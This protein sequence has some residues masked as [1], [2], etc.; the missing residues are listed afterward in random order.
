MTRHGRDTPA[1]LQPTSDICEKQLPGT[2]SQLVRP[3]QSTK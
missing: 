2:D 1:E 3:K